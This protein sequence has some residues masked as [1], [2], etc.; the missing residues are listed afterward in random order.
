MEYEKDSSKKPFF[1]ASDNQ[2]VPYKISS[3]LKLLIQQEFTV[4]IK[5]LSLSKGKT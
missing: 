3:R 4:L 5:K 2:L 1:L